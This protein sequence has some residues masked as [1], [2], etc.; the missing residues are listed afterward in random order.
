MQL[1]GKMAPAEKRGHKHQKYRYRVRLL[2]RNLR[3]VIKVHVT[4]WLERLTGRAL[5]YI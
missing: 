1:P 3:S 2:V 5:I 4:Q